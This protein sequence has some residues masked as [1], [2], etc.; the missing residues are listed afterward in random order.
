MVIFIAVS[1]SPSSPLHSVYK[2]IGTPFQYIQSGFSSFGTSVKNSFSVIGDY[3]EVK[4]EISVLKEEND[5]LKNLESE[6]DRLK[7]ENEEVV[8]RFLAEHPW[9][10]LEKDPLI[11]NGMRTF[12]PHK[13]GCDGFFAA[14]MIRTR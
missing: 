14:K 1:S 9:F 12:T 8:G 5:T 2:V 3:S 7:A 4:D 10:R 6:N 13:D 11:P